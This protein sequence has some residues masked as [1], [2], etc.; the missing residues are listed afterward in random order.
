MMDRFRDAFHEEAQELLSQLE[1]TLLSLDEAREDQS[2]INSVFRTIH[3]IKGSASMFGFQAL[4]A[5]AHS[6]EALLEYIRDGRAAVSGNLVNSMLECRDYM[7]ELL[8]NDESETDTRAELLI[9]GLSECILPS[10]AYAENGPLREKSDAGSKVQP[11]SHGS[12]PSELSAEESDSGSERTYRLHFKPSH[13][14]F[15]NGTNPLSLLEELA[16]IGEFTSLCQE[17]VPKLSLLD[18]ERCYFHW[19]IFLTTRKTEAFIRELFAFVEGHCE[20][21]IELISDLSDFIDDPEYRRIGEILMERGIVSADVIERSVRKQRRL[22]EILV[23]EGIPPHEVDAALRE[24]EHLKRVGERVHRDMASSSVRVGAAKL[25]ELVDMVGELVTVQARLSQIAGELDNPG[26]GAIAEQ[27]ER[28]TAEL[29]DSAMSIR[30]LPIATTFSKYNRLVRD[31]SRELGKETELLTEGGETEL[32]KTVI[33]KLTDPLMHIIRNCLDHGIEKPEIRKECGKPARGTI[34]LA[35][36]HTGASVTITIQDDGGGINRKLV[37]EKAISKGLIG[38]DTDLS[39]DQCLRLIFEPGFSTAGK[40][41]TVSGRGVGM[42]VVK[43]GIESLGGSVS[44]RSTEGSGTQM[45][46]K[47]PLTLAIIEG[48]LV[49]IGAEHFIIPLS[50]VEECLEFRTGGTGTAAYPHAPGGNAPVCTDERAFRALRS[51]GT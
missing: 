7:H 45:F 40:V 33:E 26:L 15:T 25:D 30:M 16:G 14:I 31:L 12:L 32:D 27:V 1:G 47:L 4:S 22:G 6:V 2:L 43:K 49:E 8:E 19:D 35:A 17:S 18:A 28:L 37:R 34:K 24:Q 41:T 13:D 51:G 5:F 21:S 36:A 44:I 39:D 50:F 38:A 11:G 3:T 23:A 42:D 46:L 48:L 10:P 20:L 9:A 29:R